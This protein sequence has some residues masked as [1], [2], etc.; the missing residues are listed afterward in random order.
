MIPCLPLIQANMLNEELHIMSE[1][2]HPSVADETR[3]PDSGTIRCDPSDPEARNE[4]GFEAGEG[5]S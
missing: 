2:N 4:S 3:I 1:I 5:Y